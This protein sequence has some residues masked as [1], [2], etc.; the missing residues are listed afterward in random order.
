MVP[1][2]SFDLPRYA[3]PS[4]GTGLLFVQ[5]RSYY[6]SGLGNTH[7]SPA[8]GATHQAG[9][10]RNSPHGVRRDTVDESVKRLQIVLMVGHD[11][12]SVLPSWGHHTRS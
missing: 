11:G 8:A 9:H 10:G 1:S 2:A 7:S 5:M 4:N 6:T 12:P 3:P